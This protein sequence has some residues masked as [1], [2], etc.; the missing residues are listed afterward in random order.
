MAQKERNNHISQSEVDPSPIELSNK[1]VTPVDTLNAASYQTLK[2]STS[3]P[4]LES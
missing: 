3:E 4:I 2:Q 1:N